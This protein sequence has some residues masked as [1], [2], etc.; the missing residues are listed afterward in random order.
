VLPRLPQCFLK[1]KFLHSGEKIV[2]KRL[3]YLRFP[4]LGLFSYF[5]K[6]KFYFFREI[7]N[8]IYFFR[9]IENWIYFS[10]FTKKKFFFVKLKIGTFFRILAHCGARMRSRMSV[11]LFFF[12]IVRIICTVTKKIH[13]GH[14]IDAKN[15]IIFNK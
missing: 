13:Y 2:K 4:E 14:I 9:E 12:Q 11:S 8:W 5:T 15:E 10:Y 6:N 7:E 1:K 3:F